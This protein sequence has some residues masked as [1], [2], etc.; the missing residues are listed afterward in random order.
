MWPRCS[1][2]ALLHASDSLECPS[3]LRSDTV[4]NLRSLPGYSRSLGAVF[5]SSALGGREV[6]L[7]SVTSFGVDGGGQRSCTFA[8]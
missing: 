1:T 4:S 5:G 2:A 3:P 6:E 7:P 8:S